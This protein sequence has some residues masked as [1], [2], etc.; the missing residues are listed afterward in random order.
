MHVPPSVRDDLIVGHLQLV[1]YWAGR[2]TGAARNSRVERDDLIQ[3]GNLAL[4]QAAESWNPR[5]SRGAKFASYA[6][7]WICYRMHAVTGAPVDITGLDLDQLA[8]R[9]D[10]LA[11]AFDEREN[12]KPRLPKLVPFFPITS[13]VPSSPCPHRGAIRVGS[14]LCC[15]VCHKSG[16]NGHPL[17]QPSADDPKPERR[18]TPRVAKPSKVLTR[19]EKRFRIYGE[20]TGPHQPK[21]G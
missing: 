4:V 1:T 9:L 18:K 3:T 15:A 14:V 19:K 7:V 8:T 2:F 21:A 11:N 12:R 20:P 17:L 13:F 16:I 5:R 10:D 6:A